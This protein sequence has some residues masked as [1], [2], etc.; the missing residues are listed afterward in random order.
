MK[1]Y[2]GLRIVVWKM[3]CGDNKYAGGYKVQNIDMY[4]C[5][6][7]VEMSGG[8]PFESAYKEAEILAVIIDAE[9]VLNNKIIRKSSTG[10]YDE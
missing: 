3:A 6:A 7:E 9:L 8:Q 10:V 4:S 2:K 1:L 5:K